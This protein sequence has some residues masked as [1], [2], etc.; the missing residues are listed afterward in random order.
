MSRQVLVV[1]AGVAGLFSALYARSAGFEVTVVDR[2][3][4][5][6]ATTSFGNIGLIVPSHFVPLAAPGAVAQGLRWM[7]QPDSPFYVRPT[8]D[9][10]L[11]GWAWRFW[12]ASSP[13][14]A[15]R[16][17]PLLRDLHRASKRAYLELSERLGDPFELEPT[18][19]LMLCTTEA[20]LEAEA[21][22]AA[23]AIAL[24]LP[25]RVL[26]RAEAA[27][28][29]PGVTLDVVGGV[30]YP[31][32][33]RLDPDR[34][35]RAL[36]A[37]LT[38]SGVVFRWHE[39]VEGLAVRGST[40]EGVRLARAGPGAAGA[41]GRAAGAVE[42]TLAADEVVLA[43]GVWSEGLARTAGLR[44]PMRAGKGYSLTLADPPERPSM[45]AIL[46]EGHVALSPMGGNVR[47]GGTMEIGGVREGV[48]QDR[49][50]GIVRSV[51][52]ALPAFEERTFA[53]AAPWYGFR[54]CSPDGLPY[55]GRS[56]RLRNLVVATGHA[57]IGVSL[58]AVTGKL[59]GELLEGASPSLPL[60]PLH[61][62]RYA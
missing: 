3:G 2:E 4:P 57:M 54:P 16:A 17:G 48:S 30:Y 61:P 49:V 14:R 51:T 10:E 42:E 60:E 39:R 33:A 24:G 44:L 6:R 7:L 43:A 52:R 25:A 58:G 59:V 22:V 20:G 36:Q 8:L 19:L 29:E 35:M 23:R 27:E 38:S 46:A 5:E 53:G 15:R 55:L 56:R 26:G 21:A 11:L 28:L 37:E 1:G 12:R 50:R 32:D 62:D 31:E 18:G 9:P 41:P 45:P 40:V 13:A 34:L 47:F